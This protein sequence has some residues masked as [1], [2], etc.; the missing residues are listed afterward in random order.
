M[1]SREDNLAFLSLITSG[2]LNVRDLVKVVGEFKL[3]DWEEAFQLAWD[4]GRLG[5][6]VVFAP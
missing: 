4:N 5:Q 3:E 2:V 1:Y 6:L